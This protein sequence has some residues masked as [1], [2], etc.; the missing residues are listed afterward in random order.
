MTIDFSDVNSGAK[1]H[2]ADLHIHS[3]GEEGSFD[4]TD[5]TMTPQNIVDTAISKNL[6][7]ISIT[8][9]NEIGNVKVALAHAE[10]KTFS[11]FLV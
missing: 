3:F 6:S 9:H 1:F 4:V 7:I 10:G 8:D 2:R 5:N 11:L